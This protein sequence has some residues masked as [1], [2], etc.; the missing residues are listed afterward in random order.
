MLQNFL[1]F[2]GSG[3]EYICQPLHIPKHKKKTFSKFHTQRN[4]LLTHA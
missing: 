3:G 2:S 1:F 4:W